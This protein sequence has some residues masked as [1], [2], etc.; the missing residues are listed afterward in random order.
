M[1]P[2]VR[3]RTGH[4]PYLHLVALIWAVCALG[5]AGAVPALAGGEGGGDR[6]EI[7]RPMSAERVTRRFDFEERLTNPGTLP[8]HWIRAQHDPPHRIR[9]GFPIWNQAVLDYTVSAAGEGSVRLPTRGGSASLLLDPGVVPVF[10][11]ADY[12]VTAMVRTLGVDHARARLAVRLLDAGGAA[13]PASEASSE[14]IDTGGR[15]MQV[16]VHVPGNE[17]TAVSLQIEL[18]LEQPGPVGDL[19]FEELEVV[20]EDFTGSAWFDE[21]K[22]VQVPRVELWTDSPGNLI[23]PDEKPTVSLFLRDLVGKPLDVRLEALDADHRVVDSD[24]VRFDGGRLERTWSP[25]LDL[26]GWYRVRVNVVQEGAPVGGAFTDLVWLS[27]VG[28]PAGKKPKNDFALSIGDVPTGGLDELGDLTLRAGVGRV[29]TDLWFPGA[30]VDRARSAA[31][32]GLSNRLTPLSRELGIV[33]PGLP[34]E[35]SDL[36]GA[37]GPLE[38]I[39]DAQNDGA[40]WLDPLLVDLGSRIRWW[41]IGALDEALDG[42]LLPDL[43]AMV[44]R[45]RSLVPGAV[46]ELPWSPFN[47]LEPG[48]VAPGIAVSEDFGPGVPGEEIESVLSG[49]LRPT[50]RGGLSGWDI[51]RHTSVF[52]AEDQERVGVGPSLDGMLR[53]ALFAWAARNDQ[54]RGHTLRLDDGWRWQGGRRAQLMPNPSAAAWLTLAGMLDGRRAEPLERII[55]GV[56]GMLLVPENERRG[57]EPIAVFWPGAGRP[58]PGTIDLLFGDGP[59]RV[60]DRFGNTASIEPGPIEPTR[61]QT[62]VLDWDRGLVYVEGV[63]ADLLRFAASVRTEP[64]LIETRVEPDTIELV[65]D[66]PWPSAIRG[67][68]FLVEPGGLSTGDVRARDRGWKISPR[69]GPFA[70]DPGRSMRI[71]IEIE[72]SAA[73]ESGERPLIVDIDLTSPTFMGLMRIRRRVRMGL[74]DLTMHVSS[75]VVPGSGDIVVYAEITNTGPETQVVH[76]Y[77]SAPGFARQRSAPTPL[78]PGQQVIKAFAFEA[79]RDVLKGEDIGVGVFVRE[80]GSRLRRTIHVD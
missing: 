3:P 32:V 73:V 27:P 70:I 20:P 18:L 54:T 13:L 41:R 69:Q 22:V 60:I 55:P 47:R 17:P 37:R 68:Y 77:A 48:L 26:Y 50:E 78:T 6:P 53:S 71:P 46:L 15:W 74:R 62:H 67:R 59:V 35:V 57:V 19:P 79:G 52:R 44:S 4:P 16:L 24:T 23:P 1:I 7:G 63:D 9:P 11:D 25:D 10:P 65:M 12:V 58:P 40:S 38:A 45:L 76:A 28:D 75:R 2:L 5:S 30:P 43:G 80:R 66:N 14:P 42:S 36:R 72:A 64:G 61:V 21:I 39:A 31:L 34:P 51:P 49:F 56:E 8:R 33:I 29:L